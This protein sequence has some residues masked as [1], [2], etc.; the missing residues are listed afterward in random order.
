M[1]LSSCLVSDGC[2]LNVSQAESQVVVLKCV[3]VLKYNINQQWIDLRSVAHR[4]DI[5]HH[6]ATAETGFSLNRPGS[7]SGRH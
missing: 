1:E 6:W 4:V 2:S 5:L 3:V 7:S